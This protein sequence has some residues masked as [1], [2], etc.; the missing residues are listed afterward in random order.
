VV[1]INFKV[2]TW[3]KETI[4]ISQQINGRWQSFT[5]RIAKALR[6]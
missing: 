6:L 3:V 5:L 1:V 4:V 2:V